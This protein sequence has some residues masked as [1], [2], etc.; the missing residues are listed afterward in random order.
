MRLVVHYDGLTGHWG[1]WLKDN[2]IVTPR[3][4]LKICK[5][6]ATLDRINTIEL[7]ST[8]PMDRKYMTKLKRETVRDYNLNKLSGEYYTQATRN[9]IAAVDGTTCKDEVINIVYYR[10]DAGVRT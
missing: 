3:K 10:Q 4:A 5:A 8:I 1:H 6:K 7:Q 9:I 2:T